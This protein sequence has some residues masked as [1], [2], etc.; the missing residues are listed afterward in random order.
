MKKKQRVPEFRQSVHE[1]SP[2]IATIGGGLSVLHLPSLPLTRGF[3]SAQKTSEAAR[4]PKLPRLRVAA[5][6]SLRCFRSR[7]SKEPYTLSGC[8]TPTDFVPLSE[9]R[10]T[11]HRKRERQARHGLQASSFTFMYRTYVNRRLCQN[12]RLK[13]AYSEFP[14]SRQYFVVF[15]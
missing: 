6:S 4:Y 15:T 2:T 8:R 3:A 11:S 14:C 12:S 9:K 7:P 1:I 13:A 10:N 5:S